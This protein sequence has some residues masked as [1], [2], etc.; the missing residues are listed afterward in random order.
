M[1]RVGTYVR[2]T[3]ESTSHFGL[4]GVIIESDEDKTKIR[5]INDSVIKLKTCIFN[6][7]FDIVEDQNCALKTFAHEYA[8]EFIPQRNK[9]KLNEHTNVRKEIKMKKLFETKHFFNGKDIDEMCNDEVFDEIIMM[10]HKIEK[11]ESIKSDSK[12]V[13]KEIKRIKKA[14][15]KLIEKTD[16]R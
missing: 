15:K 3:N 4:L 12:I 16:N 14:V 11:L 5:L 7:F 8:G 10:E 2:N 6:H 9:T 13:K 1:Y